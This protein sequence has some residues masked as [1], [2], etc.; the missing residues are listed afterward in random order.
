M[1]EMLT[2]YEHTIDQKEQTEKNLNKALDLL[3]NKT[4]AYRRYYEWRII[5][6]ERQRQQYS[7]TLAKRFYEEKVKRVCSI[8]GPND[9]SLWL[10]FF[11]LEIFNYL[12]KFF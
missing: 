4:I 2:Q 3:Y 11:L 5:H 1:R 10:F 9:W 8:A 6:I 7:L 12:E